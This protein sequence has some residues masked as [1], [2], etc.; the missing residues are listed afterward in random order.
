MSNYTNL[1]AKTSIDELINLISKLDFFITSDSGPMH[2]AAALQVPTVSIFGPTNYKETSQWMNEKGMI[3]KKNL[4]CQPCMK[5]K[6][7]LVHHNC[8]KFIKSSEVLEVINRM[9]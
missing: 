1:A 9:S 8:M 2:I 7:P 5:R 6:C 4:K 3:V